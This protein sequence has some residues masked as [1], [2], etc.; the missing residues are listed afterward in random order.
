MA[1]QLTNKTFGLWTVVGRSDY[2]GNG[3]TPQA[4]WDCKC[5]CGTRKPIRT[6]QLTSGATQSCGCNR[7]RP[8]ALSYGPFISRS[9]AAKKGLTIY[10]TGKSCKQGHIAPRYVKGICVVCTA[11]KSLARWHAKPKAWAKGI[12][13]FVPAFEIAQLLEVGTHFQDEI[14]CRSCGDQNPVRYTKTGRC[15][16]CAAKRT[17]EARVK[18]EARKKMNTTRRKHYNSLPIQKRKEN[19]EARKPYFNSYMR[20]RRH[21]DPMVSMVEALRKRQNQWLKSNKAGTTQELTGCSWEEARQHFESQFLP[22]M[23]WDNHGI[24]GWHIDHIRP[25]ASFDD[26]SDPEQQKQ[27]FHFTNLQP[28]WAKDNWAKSDKWEAAA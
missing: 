3:A 16:S 2:K 9:Q 12:E 11:E 24:H 27:C 26:L 8:S 6:G 14:K 20:D 25:C 5:Q 7:T 1:L 13:G 18:P 17:K 23:T 4:H 22:G 21:N 28:L 19:R 10:F 15:V